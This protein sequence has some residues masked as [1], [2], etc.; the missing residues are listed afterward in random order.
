MMKSLRP[1]VVLALQAVRKCLGEAVGDGLRR[2]PPQRRSPLLDDRR[3]P[4]C[5][6]C[7]CAGSRA[8]IGS[9]QTTARPPAVLH[10]PAERVDPA[11]DERHA[12][13]DRQHRG[14]RVHRPGM[15]DLLPRPLGEDARPRARSGAPS[16]RRAPSRGRPRRA[17][18]RMRPSSGAARRRSGTRAARSWPCSRASAA[19]AAPTIAGSISE[20]WFAATTI[21]PSAGTSSC[22]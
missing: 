17:A 10:G 11:R 3:V 20:K 21:G 8:S 9:P 6:P 4:P 2:P 22:P 5:S 15:A 14:T 12:L 13:L 19:S 16:A 7:R 1:D 18:R